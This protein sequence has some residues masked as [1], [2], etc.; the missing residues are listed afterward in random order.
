MANELHENSDRR[1]NTTACCRAKKA[2]GFA[3]RRWK[4]LSAGDI[5]LPHNAVGC[6]MLPNAANRPACEGR[7]VKV[8]QARTVSKGDGERKPMMNSR[9]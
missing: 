1:L 9:W 2:R 6:G 8:A 4:G 7:R 3:N 5:S